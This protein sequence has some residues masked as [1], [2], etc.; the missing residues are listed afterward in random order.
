MGVFKEEVGAL[1]DLFRKQVRIY[2]DACDFGVLATPE[3]KDTMRWVLESLLPLE[4]NR[5]VN[6]V[7]RPDYVERRYALIVYWSPGDGII[8]N[9]VYVND[10]TRKKEFFE[11][12][13]HPIHGG[14]EEDY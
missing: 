6:K 1:E 12:D 5:V 3:I 2:P 13:L 11:I 9:V 7:T 8:A 4:G 14:E 10:K